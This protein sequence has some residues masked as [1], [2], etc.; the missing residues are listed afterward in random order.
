MISRFGFAPRK[1]GLSIAEFQNHWRT[2]HATAIRGMVGLKRYWQNHAV[3]R[4]DEPL[5]PW[6]G[7]DACAQIEADTLLDLDMAFVTPYYHGPVREDEM[8]FIHHAAFGFLLCERALA[9]GRVQGE[10]VRL[11]TFMRLAPLRAPQALADALLNA[12]PAGEF[13][14]REVFLALTAAASAQR[15]SLFDALEILWFSDA[16]KAERHTR[17]AVAREHRTRLADVVRG[18]ERLIARVVEVI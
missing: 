10:G 2:S 8:R 17:S 13:D 18:T 9:E 16:D 4:D 14:G 5:L 7:F 3:L 1:P 11:M 6:P 15:T 12:R